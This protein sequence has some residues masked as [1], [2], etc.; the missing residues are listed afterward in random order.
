MQAD[1]VDGCPSTLFLN[2]LICLQ[3][4]DNSFWTNDV[5]RNVFYSQ[6]VELTCYVQLFQDSCRVYQVL[7]K[8]Y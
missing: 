6:V 7:K 8:R 5:S 2:L 1:R 3:C 4:F